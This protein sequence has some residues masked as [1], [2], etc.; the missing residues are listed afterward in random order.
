MYQFCGMEIK[1]IIISMSDDRIRVLLSEERKKQEI[2]VLLTPNRAREAAA[3]NLTI[4]MEVKLGVIMQTVEI[5]NIKLAKFWLDNVIFPRVT[6]PVDKR[7]SKN[8][9]PDHEGWAT[10]H[11]NS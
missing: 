9:D 10:R 7:R 1:G 5:A 2:D 8:D 11:L 4:R 3:H 6:K